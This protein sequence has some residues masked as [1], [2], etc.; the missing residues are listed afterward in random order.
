M[1][2]FWKLV[3]WKFGLVTRSEYEW[4]EGHY[5]K[6][7]DRYTEL[8]EKYEDMLDDDSNSN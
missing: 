7:V 3:L 1:N 4:L 6:L 8:A 2:E 5:L